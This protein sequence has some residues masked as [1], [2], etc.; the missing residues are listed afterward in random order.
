M[1]S[2]PNPVAFTIGGIDIRWYALFM[3]AGIV[4]GLRAARAAGFDLAAVVPCDAPFLP[5]DL[6]SRFRAAIGE[7]PAIIAG[8]V[9]RLHP[10]VGLWRVATLPAL[11]AALSTRRLRLEGVC[12]EVGASVL[13]ARDAGWSQNAFFNI[14]TP[15][16]LA[17]A[18]ARLSRKE[19]EGA[20]R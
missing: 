18:E 11:E 10:A 5:T 15:D 8:D 13:D 4:A 6:V 7:A 19:R 17:A 14:N 9:G 2:P 16:D 20:N 3:L 12:R 1:P